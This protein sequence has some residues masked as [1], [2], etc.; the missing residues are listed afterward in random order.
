M[1]AVEQC[2]RQ[3]KHVLDV[4]LFASR[5]WSIRKKRVNSRV[6][7]AAP[8][9]E[10]KCLLNANSGQYL[11]TYWAGEVAKRFRNVV[12]PA[13]PR[14]REVVMP[15]KHTHTCSACVQRC[16]REHLPA[17]ATSRV[18]Q[19][20]SIYF[21]QQRRQEMRLWNCKLTPQNLTSPHCLF[22]HILSAAPSFEGA[23]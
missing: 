2:G 3:L 18:R 19:Q 15:V 11:H 20:P 4:G 23:H 10:N 22:F 9:R 14:V 12:S 5:S 7:T 1:Y 6:R 13:V 8:S 17:S 16:S 21:Y